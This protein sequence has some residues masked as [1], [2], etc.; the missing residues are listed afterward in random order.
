M[1]EIIT[2]EVCLRKRWCFAPSWKCSGRNRVSSWVWTNLLCDI[3]M[4]AHYL[5][6][7]RSSLLVW[8]HP[9]LS[10]LDS[11][12][13]RKA[14]DGPTRVQTQ[15][16]QAI[17]GLS[18]GVTGFEVFLSSLPKVVFVYSVNFSITLICVLCML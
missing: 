6:N 18:C 4:K 9:V 3:E 2:H 15:A 16:R 8:D 10:N 7:S 13:L 1:L 11:F 14:T 17:T 12:L 5:F